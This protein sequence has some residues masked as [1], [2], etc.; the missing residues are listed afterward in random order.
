MWGASDALL[1]AIRLAEQ[2]AYLR[3]TAWKAEFYKGR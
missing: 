2:T 3:L 1:S